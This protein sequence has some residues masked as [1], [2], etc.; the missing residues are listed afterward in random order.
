MTGTDCGLF[1]H[2]SVSVI[3]ES[4]CILGYMRL[5]YCRYARVWC[6]FLLVYPFVLSV[7][8][9]AKACCWSPA[10]TVICGKWNSHTQN[11]RINQQKHTLDMCIT[12]A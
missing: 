5:S 3:F 2:K 8:V 6:V 4:P 12:T 9:E 10:I 11:K 7:S 1:T